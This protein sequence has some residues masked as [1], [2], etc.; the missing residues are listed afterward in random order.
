MLTVDE[1]APS[2]GFEAN[3]WNAS[4]GAGGN[5]ARD[6]RQAQRR[7]V[8]AYLNSPQG[9]DQICKLVMVPMGGSPADAQAFL[10]RERVKWV[11]IIKEANITLQ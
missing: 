4:V 1:Q 11:L 10:D 9:K 2:Q 8:N 5:A 7:W 6:H 3:G